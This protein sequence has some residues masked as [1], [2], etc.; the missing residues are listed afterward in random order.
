MSVT[1]DELLL[2]ERQEF[3]GFG[4]VSTLNGSNSGKGPGCAAT[5]N[6]FDWGNTS[7]INPIDVIGKFLLVNVEDHVFLLMIL[8]IL[9]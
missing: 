3:F 9:R 8:I 2:G 7:S 4:I 1:I 6:V 5:S